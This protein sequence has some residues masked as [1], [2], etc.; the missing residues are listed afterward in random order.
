MLNASHHKEIVFTTPTGSLRVK[1]TDN[2]PVVTKCGRLFWTKGSGYS[3]FAVNYPRFRDLGYSP[4]PRFTRKDGG[5]AFPEKWSTYCD[6]VA[7]KIKLDNW[8]QAPDANIALVGGYGG[9]VPIDVDTNN[10]EILA[11]VLQALPHCRV[12]RFGSKGFC[13]MC[14]HFDPD[15]ASGKKRFKSV[16]WANAAVTEPMVEIKA[17]GQNIT[18]PPSRHVKTG[19]LYFWFNPETN[20]PIDSP[21]ALSELPIITDQDI[22]RLR[23][24]LV[25]WARKPYEPK[26]R[27]TANKPSSTRLEAYARAA[28]ESEAAIVGKLTEGR[29]TALFKGVCKVGWSVHHGFVPEADLINAFVS[30][31]EANG[32]L[33]REGLR[34]IE[35]SIA[36]GL[37]WSEGDPLPR[38]EDRPNPHSIPPQAPLPDEPP[39][40]RGRGKA[41]L[42]LVKKN[43]GAQ[44]APNEE[45]VEPEG[46][47]DAELVL[48][49]GEIAIA[50]RLAD[51]H[52]RVLRFV[53][54][55][56]SWHVYDGMRWQEDRKAFGFT[57][58][59]EECLKTALCLHK[60]KRKAMT[61][62]QKVAAVNKLAQNDPRMI[63]NAEEF[64]Q[65]LMLLNTFSGAAEL[66]EDK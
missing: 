65:D 41:R 17:S 37:R 8:A 36:S 14:R 29:P 45:D 56:G 4:I 6:E 38:L 47:I 28:V 12:G 52:E 48:F 16:L 9:L 25:P 22:E 55:R 21:P 19:E 20:E 5:S 26:P 35:A 59:K 23:Q 40:P 10:E 66:E 64:D 44:L 58:A 57:R 31:C 18:I 46:D 42:H 49:T 43:G 50:K 2:G 61:S 3:I 15:V 54:E 30:S 27:E 11:A 39:A 60:D 62:A 7:P 63:A 32:L 1:Q 33:D 53:P 51:A 24:A 13:L 34:A